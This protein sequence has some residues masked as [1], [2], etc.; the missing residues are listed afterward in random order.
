MQD[1]AAAATSIQSDITYFNKQSYWLF[2]SICRTLL[3]AHHE[4]FE[5][6]ICVQKVNAHKECGFIQD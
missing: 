3:V 1:Q 6:K 5:V 4:S 2:M